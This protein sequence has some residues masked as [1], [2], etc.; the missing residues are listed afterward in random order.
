MSYVM[1]FEEISNLRADDSVIDYEGFKMGKRHSI[2]KSR[3]VLLQIFAWALGIRHKI[4]G[5]NYA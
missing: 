1:D 4:Y 2:F 5:C 3:Y